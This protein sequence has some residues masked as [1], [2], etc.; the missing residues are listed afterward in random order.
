MRGRRDAHE[1]LTRWARE[2]RDPE[3]PT[4]WLHAPS[5]GEGLQARAVLE[6]LR[7]RRPDVQAVFTHF[8]PSAEALAR[9]MP[10]DLADYLPWD[11]PSAVGPVL[12]ALA[13]AVVAFTKTEVWPVLVEEA[14]RRGIPT[15]MIAGTLRPT[16]GRARWPARH[17]L[18]PAWER[19]SVLGAVS[20]ADAEGLQGLGVPEGVTVVTG[21]P[22]VDSAVERAA[23]ADP[24]SPVLAPFLAH[25]QPTVVAGST[26]PADEDVLVP[27]LARVKAACPELRVVVAPHEPE[28]ERVAVLVER[29]AGAGF[30]GAT[31]THVEGRGRLAPVDAVVVDRVGPLAHLY[32]VGT[33]AYVGGGFHGAGLHSVLEPAAAALP[34]VFG[35][36]HQ[37]ASAAADL[38]GKEAARVAD[39]P[40]A[41]ARTVLDWLQDETLRHYTGYRGHGYIHAHRG[42]ADRTASLLERFLD[43]PTDSK[44]S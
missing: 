27:A 10:V 9:A 4:V 2:R 41:L 23:A 22:G 18:R 37:N 3:R 29:L 1:R 42:A 25:P 13:P 36:R 43:D 38:L 7:V 28:T 8:S 34:T 30:V 31:L 12:D 32:T 19:L 16:S 35:P 20:E 11:V 14:A 40:E 26:W 24:E 44:R 39:G 17:L 5:V 15:A 21:D 33:V 6:A